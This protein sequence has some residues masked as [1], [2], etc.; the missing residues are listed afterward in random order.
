MTIG[1]DDLIAMWRETS[2]DVP[3]HRSTCL[4]DHEWARLLAQETDEQER[5]RAA[6]H[7]AACTRCADEYRILQPLEQWS[8]EVERV[9]SPPDAARVNRWPAWRRWW[10]SPRPALAM[11]AAIVLLVTNGAM[12]FQVAESRRETSQ[13]QTRLAT[14]EQA[15]SA[16]RASQAALREQAQKGISA[17][18]QLKTLQQRISELST[19]RLAGAIVDLEPG[20]GEVVRGAADPQ[21]VVRPLASAVTIILNHPPLSARS[22]LEVAIEDD[23]RQV[24]WTDRMA[25]DQ[26]SAALALVLPPEYPAGRYVIRLFDVT[27]GRTFL[28]MYRFVIRQG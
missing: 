15:L 13:L 18:E 20:S 9:L 3:S 11:T 4:Q 24:R 23:S 19:P 7:I 17:E 21:I 2:T 1:D 10:L 12:I 8:A 5:V 22:T 27:R 16:T 25:R 28:A 14:S 6:S 26:D